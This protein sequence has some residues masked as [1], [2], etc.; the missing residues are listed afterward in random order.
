[1]QRIFAL[2]NRLDIA[3]TD[4]SSLIDSIPEAAFPSPSLKIPLPYPSFVK[5]QSPMTLPP[6]D[7]I[8]PQ[9]LRKEALKEESNGS[10]N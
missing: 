1:M 2:L 3:P 4:E 5:A 10:T 8:A 6:T 9:V 7:T